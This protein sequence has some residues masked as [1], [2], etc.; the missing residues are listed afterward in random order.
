MSNST[1]VKG[2]TFFFEH[3]YGN[4]S[5]AGMRQSAKKFVETE[6]YNPDA[7]YYTGKKVGNRYQF[8]PQ[9]P[10]NKIIAVQL[11]VG[12]AP[13][14]IYE[15]PLTEQKVEGLAK[16]VECVNPRVEVWGGRILQ[17]W[18][19]RFAGEKRLFQRKI[20]APLTQKEIIAVKKAG[21]EMVTN[22]HR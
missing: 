3:D 12:A 22:D 19:V 16:L 11:K 7:I 15:D 18:M 17:S 6:A 20:L 10:Q 4:G 2:K 14:K 13:V 9:I 8:I 21:Q 5:M 1:Q